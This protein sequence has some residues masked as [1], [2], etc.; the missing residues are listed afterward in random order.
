MADL[1]Q[2]PVE[3]QSYYLLNQYRKDSQAELY[4]GYPAFDVNNF[5]SQTDYM[6]PET[7]AKYKYM[8]QNGQTEDIISE[9]AFNIDPEILKKA[10]VE[11]TIGELINGTT[12]NTTKDI[13]PIAQQAAMPVTQQ[14]LE[15]NI[16]TAINT[17]TPIAQAQEIAQ[18]EEATKTKGKGHGLGNGGT[19]P[20]IQK[21]IDNGNLPPGLA[22]K[23]PQLQEANDDKDQPK[24]G[25][26]QNLK[27]L[28]Q[29]KDEQKVTINELK[30]RQKELLKQQ[31][32]DGASKKE[33]NELQAKFKDERKALRKE[34]KPEKKAE[35]KEFFSGL[36]E[37]VK[38]AFDSEKKSGWREH[39]KGL[40]K[41]IRKDFNEKYK[42]GK[43]DD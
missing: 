18:Q 20:G 16:S 36:K 14:D 37:K 22:K 31:K 21:K 43:D 34:F 8:L 39:F 25:F 33:L 41:D 13:G 30:A 7:D 27:E 5:F 42:A 32:A 6:T 1:S 10:P 38:P 15:N 26:W 24:K 17:N 11:Q 12:A 3:L 23:F 2:I 40:K 29:I 35:W 9:N 19:P 4:S 28:K